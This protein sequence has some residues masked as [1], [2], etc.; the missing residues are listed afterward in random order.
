MWQKQIMTLLH[1]TSDAKAAGKISLCWRH[2][3]FKGAELAASPGSVSN[4]CIF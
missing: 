2:F 3:G 1:I 4:R